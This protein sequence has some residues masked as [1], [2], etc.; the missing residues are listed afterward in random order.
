M[1]MTKTDKEILKIFSKN[2]YD[3][4]KEKIQIDIVNDV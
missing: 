3:F 2:I 1:F 4:G